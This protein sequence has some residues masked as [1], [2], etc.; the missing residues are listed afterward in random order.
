MTDAKTTA[1]SR[2]LAAAIASAAEATNL[3]RPE[4]MKQHRKNLRGIAFY[5]GLDGVAQYKAEYPEAAPIRVDLNAIAYTAKPK[6]YDAYLSSLAERWLLNGT[7]IGSSNAED[8]KQ[9]N[10][11]FATSFPP[12]KHF[13]EPLSKGRLNK[14]KAAFA[15]RGVPLDIKHSNTMSKVRSA[16]KAARAQQNPDRHL[17]KVGVIADNILVMGGQPFRVER[18]GDRECIRVLIGGKRRRL[19]LEELVWIADRLVGADP[20]DTTTVRSMGDMAYSGSDPDFASGAA[21]KIPELVCTEK[22]VTGQGSLDC[23]DPLEF[24]DERWAK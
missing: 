10:E 22:P 19:Y 17:A 12:S 24:D 21:I 13:S 16:A 11:R 9:L 20:L 1:L 7:A 8:V 5:Q 14:I 23:V 4:R 6:G 18:N 3:P 15:H 2:G